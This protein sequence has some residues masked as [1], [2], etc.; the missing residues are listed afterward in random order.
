MRKGIQKVMVVETESP[1]AMSNE[2]KEVR[3]NVHWPEGVRPSFGNMK[4][5]KEVNLTF[6]G[7]VKGMDMHEYGSS[8]D[9]TVMSKQIK[10]GGIGTDLK[11]LRQSR[12]IST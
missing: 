5:G 1:P 10:L 4:M 2:R 9:L 7:K 11:K 3:V 12:R 6:R 8:L